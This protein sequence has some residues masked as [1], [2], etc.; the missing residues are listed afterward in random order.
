MRSEGLIFHSRPLKEQLCS[1][2]RTLAVVLFNIEMG[3]YIK[4]VGT[5]VFLDPYV[6]AIS[7]HQA[8]ITF[9][10]RLRQ[11]GSQRTNETGLASKFVKR[12]LCSSYDYFPKELE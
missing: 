6:P 1:L 11:D 8:N 10:L 9:R 2:Y 5:G 7:L 4:N 3:M 12:R